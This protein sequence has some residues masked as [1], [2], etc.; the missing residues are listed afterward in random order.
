MN[1]SNAIL[2]TLNVFVCVNKISR[3]FSQLTYKFPFQYKRSN[4]FTFDTPANTG[5]V[6][7]SQSKTK[8]VSSS[9]SEDF[10][11]NLLNLKMISIKFF[12]L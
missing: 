1:K 5:G 9:Y 4:D 3:G 6:R 2:I 11:A 8:T 10:A 7:I 12:D